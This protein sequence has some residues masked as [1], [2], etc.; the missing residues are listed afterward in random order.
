MP[1]FSR[2]VLYQ[3]FLSPS[4]NIFGEKVKLHI[5]V[6]VLIQTLPM[7]LSF[8]AIGT[9]LTEALQQRNLILRL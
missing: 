3:I 9:Y 5:L 6:P 2:G 7:P 8:S 4:G 1:S